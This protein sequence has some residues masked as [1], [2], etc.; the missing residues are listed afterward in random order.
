MYEGVPLP[1][2]I[3]FAVIVK[4]TIFF[5]LVALLSGVLVPLRGF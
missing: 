2:T 3:F 5:V 4:F 1:V